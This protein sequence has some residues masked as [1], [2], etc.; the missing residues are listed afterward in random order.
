[1]GLI[2]DDVHRIAAIPTQIVLAGEDLYVGDV[3]EYHSYDEAQEQAIMVRRTGSG[4]II[5]GIVGKTTVVNEPFVLIKEGRITEFDTSAWKVG[6]L[7]YGD[8]SG[9]IVNYKVVEAGIIN[10]NI[11][12]VVK[13][14]TTDG[15]IDILVKNPTEKA[16]E[17]PY[18]NDSSGLAADNVK[19]AIDE[20]EARTDIGED[21]LQTLENKMLGIE[22]GATRDQT[23]LEIKTLYESMPNT[24]EYDD[25]EQFKVS[26]INITQPVDLDFIEKKD[27]D[28]RNII[29]TLNNP[30]CHIPLSISLDYAIGSGSIIFSRAQNTING[31]TYITRNNE[32]RYAN[33]DEPRFEK[34]GLLLEGTSTNLQIESNRFDNWSGDV[35]TINSII[36]PDNNLTA[37]SVAFTNTNK[38]YI[39]NIANV[40][41]TK[42]VTYSVWLKGSIGGEIIEIRLSDSITNTSNATQTITLTKYWKRYSVTG[43][44][45]K[46][47]GQDGYRIQVIGNNGDTV[48]IWGVQVEEGKLMTSL[49]PTYGA[50]TQ[51]NKDIC[52]LDFVD[53]LLNAEIDYSLMFDVNL[54]KIHDADIAR[55]IFGVENEEF[56]Y[57]RIAIDG[58]VESDGLGTANSSAYIDE[59]FRYTNI[60]K[61]GIHTGYV[62]SG[63]TLLED[64]GVNTNEVTIIGPRTII[65][66]NTGHQDIPMF[67]HLSNFRVFDFALNAEMLR[68]S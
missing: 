37:S 7:L 4:T 8:Y 47:G 51:R 24:N 58:T 18:T 53:N 36:A 42:Y 23:P 56:R 35:I 5:A 63:G 62:N 64:K 39:D 55:G 61:N 30:L 32:V 54:P 14:G 17:I 15:V 57:I 11:G 67:G 59:S 16:V 28:R 6:D 66:G 44:Q 10:Q 26:Q 52:R 22:S 40:L 20:V 3:V 33:N 41:D 21:R 1:M 60:S 48:H 49:I 31:T 68:L 2:F 29:G 34:E 19:D 13:V 38:V 50:A 45:A 27:E 9:G 12:S 46:I 43:V 65:L 25:A